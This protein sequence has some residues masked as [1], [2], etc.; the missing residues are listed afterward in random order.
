MPF[1]NYL[2]SCNLFFT[3][4]STQTHTDTNI[5]SCPGSVVKLVWLD[6]PGVSISISMPNILFNYTRSI[7]MK[8][9]QFTLDSHS[10]CSFSSIADTYH[11][12]NHQPHDCLLNRLF[13]RR[14]KK[15]SKLC[16]TGLCEGNSL[17]TGEFPAQRASN[18]ENVSTWWRHHGLRALD[19]AFLL[20][21]CSIP[22]NC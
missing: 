5:H 19:P 18:A 12:S 10:D 9:T 6:S 15:T 2:V 22:G 1:K 7:I 20:S 8:S 13:R 16:V 21:L 3:N 11:V 17:V 4:T 14:S